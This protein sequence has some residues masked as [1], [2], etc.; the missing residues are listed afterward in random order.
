MLNKSETEYCQLQYQD[1]W[2][3]LFI[4]N[5]KKKNALSKKLIDEII[6]FL[7]SIKNNDSLRGIVFRG[8]NNI[9]CSGADLDELQQITNKNKDYY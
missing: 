7:D 3:T 4:N 5:K 2:V 9:F 6:L 8:K 1:D